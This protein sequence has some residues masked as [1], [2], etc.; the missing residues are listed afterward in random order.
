MYESEK[1]ESQNTHNKKT[2]AQNKGRQPQYPHVKDFW[3]QVVI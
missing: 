3:H 2:Q 1:G